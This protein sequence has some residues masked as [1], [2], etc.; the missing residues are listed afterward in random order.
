MKEL[1]LVAVEA[2]QRARE[3]SDRPQRTAFHP[4]GTISSEE[5]RE[6]LR[7]FP[8]GV[9]IVTIKVGERIH[10]LTVSAFA[11]ISPSPPLVSVVIDHRHS[12]WAMLEEEEAVF[13]INILNHRQVEISNRFAWVKN[14]DRFAVGEWTTAVTGAPVLADALAWLDCTIQGRVKAGSHTIYVG[15]VRA[16]GVPEPGQRPLVYWNRG[17]RRLVSKKG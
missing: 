10:G 6:A 9:T 8:S 3:I 4:T 14:A 2:P 15:E 12:A 5:Y 16:S 13:A 7:H 1:T 11:S 17:Y